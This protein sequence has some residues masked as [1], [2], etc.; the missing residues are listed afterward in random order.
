[1]KLSFVGNNEGNVKHPFKIGETYWNRKVQYTVV[2]FE[3]EKMRVRLPDGT[4]A[5]YDIERQ[6]HIWESILG[7]EE[8]QEMERIRPAAGGRDGRPIGELVQRV[9]RKKFSAPYPADIIDQVSLAI[10]CDPAWLK[11]Y[12]AL[13]ERYDN[14]G[15]YGKH[16]VNLGIS[17]YTKYITGMI[18]VN[19]GNVAKSRLR[20][21]FST[22]RHE[23]GKMERDV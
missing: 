11:E 4:E 13:V 22:L 17:R 1:M 7:E 16:T 20:D 19:K 14:E 15:A 9:L 10:E 12:E 18:T 6:R 23:R 2:A 3:G 21:S 8:G 5:K